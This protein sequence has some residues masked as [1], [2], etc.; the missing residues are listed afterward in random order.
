MP[1]TISRT[2]VH[3]K[4]ILVLDSR[5][6]VRSKW[7]WDPWAAANE[8]YTG[9]VD[10][11]DTIPWQQVVLE[12]GMP[13]D[14][15]YAAMAQY[16]PSYG[17]SGDY[18]HIFDPCVAS[19][20]HE[21]YCHNCLGLVG[22]I[23]ALLEADGIADETISAAYSILE[24]GV[25]AHVPLRN[26]FFRNF[27]P[28]N[29]CCPIVFS[30]PMTYNKGAPGHIGDNNQQVFFVRAVDSCDGT[31]GM[32]VS[33][34]PETYRNEFRADSMHFL[35]TVPVDEI[36]GQIGLPSIPDGARLVVYCIACGSVP[37]IQI[38]GI[39]HV[40][41]P[42]YFPPYGDP[43][44]YCFRGHKHT[45]GTI[46]ECGLRLAA[47]ESNEFIVEHIAP[48]SDEIGAQVIFC[49]EWDETTIIIDE[50]E[51]KKMAENRGI[52]RSPV[53]HLQLLGLCNKK[54]DDASTPADY[55]FLALE[56]NALVA[57][58]N[59]VQTR[60]DQWKTRSDEFGEQTAQWL[61]LE[62]Q[63]LDLIGRARSFWRMRHGEGN[64][65]ERTAGIDE[66]PRTKA[67]ISQALHDIVIV[68]DDNA[69]TNA[70]LPPALRNSIDALY[71]QTRANLEATEIA[72]G[73]KQDSYQELK[74]AITDKGLP[75]LRACREYLYTVLPDGKHD[76]LL[77]EWGFEPW[78][79]PVNQKPDD[80]KL[81]E[82]GYDSATDK[83]KIRLE[84]DILADE[85][86]IESGKTPSPAPAGWKPATWD[87]FATGDE[88]FFEL[89]PL[90]E[91]NT[92]AFRARAKN[93]TGYGGYSEIWI[94]E[95]V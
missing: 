64:V 21:A 93:S 11:W 14:F 52:P 25:I 94:V 22:D 4:P 16:L 8:G 27:D 33:L 55:K 35:R 9:Y 88:P 18:E 19:G 44:G 57:A 87:V 2:I 37:R 28:A 50:K 54:D 26:L 46:A 58:L 83:I 90:V 78:D 86:I 59:E 43:Y 41:S 6:I 1:E 75:A 91:G 47:G 95:I 85:Y 53:E 73:E 40:V 61:T 65:Y 10:I 48:L 82:T 60:Y 13:H 17:G 72:Q 23:I 34:A 30:R 74:K 49:L 32:R 29:F 79:Y 20:L 36:L 76:Q 92:Y 66:Q 39:W 45:V 81:V 5:F 38:N 12:D 15:N 56:K 62:K 80:Q 84:E 89:G 71:A 3:R 77:I 42:T 51:E 7:L 69:G 63:A 67:R 68:S 31:E 70:E 24:S